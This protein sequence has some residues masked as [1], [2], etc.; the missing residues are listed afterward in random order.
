MDAFSLPHSAFA[1]LKWTVQSI[2]GEEAINELFGFTIHAT[3]KRR[4]IEAIMHEVGVEPL[5]LALVGQ[6]VSFRVGTHGPTRYGV[7]TAAEVQGHVVI[8]AEPGTRIRFEIAPRAYLLTKRRNSRIFQGLYVHQIVSIVL[9]ESGVSHRWELLRSYPKRVFCTQYDETDWD[10]VTRLLAEEGILCFFD[11]IESFPGGTTPVY[12]GPEESDWAKAAKV[13]STIGTVAGGVGGLTDNMVTD[14]IA[15]VGAGAS[16]LGDLMKPVPKDEEADD[17]LTPFTGQA[18]PGGDVDVL[19]FVD[20]S[21]GYVYVPPH[22]GEKEMK[23]VLH[24]EGGMEGSEDQITALWPSRHVRTRQSTVRDYDFRRPLLLLEAKSGTADD[25]KLLGG[26]KPLDTYA[27]H[28]EYEK[29]EVETFIAQTHLEQHRAD[30]YV[31]AGKS[32]CP[33]LG[34]GITFE[35]DAPG[36][37]LEDKRYAVVRVRHESHAPTSQSPS[38]MGPARA[39]TSGI[40]VNHEV[41]RFEALARGCARAIYEAMLSKEPIAEEAIG[42]VIRDELGAEPRKRVYKNRFECVPATVAYRPPRPPPLVRNVTESAVVVGPIG[43]GPISPGNADPNDPTA[44]NASKEIYTDRYGRVKIQ[45]HW[46]RDGKLDEHSSC[47]VRVAQTWAGA[48]FGFQFIP[49]VGMEVLVAFLRGDPD[50]PVIIGSLYNATHATPEPLPQRTTRSGIRTQSS[51]GGGGFN[52]LSF[53]DGKGVERVFVHAQKDFEEVVNDTHSLNVKNVQRVTVTK[54][55]EVSVGGDQITAVGGNH[56][57][58]VAKAQSITVQG[59]RSSAVANNETAL[60]NGNAFHVVSGVAARNVGTDEII[61]IAGDR[62][63]SVRGNLVTHVGGRYPDLKSS[64]ITYVQGSSFLTA[65]ERVVVK[66][67]TAAKDASHSSIRLE[68]G[69]S[70][71]QIEADKITLSAKQIEILGSEQIKA[72]GKDADLK[73]DKDGAKML[74]KQTAMGTPDGSGLALDGKDATLNAPG[75]TAVKGKEIKM[76][77]AKSDSD[78]P[79]NTS[80]NE[81]VPGKLKL[82]FTH[83]KPTDYGSN[84]KIANTP[85]R[86]VIEDQ[87]YEGNTDGDGLLEVPAPDTAK[88]A[89]VTLWANSKYPTQYTSGPLVWLVRIVKE[90]GDAGTPKG[91]R[92]RLR[93]LA[94]DPGTQLEPEKLDPVTAQA[95]VEFQLDEDLPATGELDDQT[96]K[97]LSEEYGTPQ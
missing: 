51:P 65:T 57:T 10:F 93:N 53:E 40:E 23:L 29:P 70:F 96:K 60:V 38:R 20:S 17:W 52:E 87:V 74:A 46:D 19:V 80:K 28:G 86:V 41:D 62:D 54:Q 55:Q 78:S 42:Q 44:N 14:T 71:L 5:E 30:A 82:V 24:D 7:V 72:K 32:Y 79:Q 25:P 56:A 45:F 97:K 13:A 39:G 16:V 3:A 4:E 81:K 77:S 83:L 85:Y 6:E 94:Y 91:A 88:A 58:L 26:E 64:A 61:S 18:G 43:L 1:P 66:A 69:D 84:N 11:H 47:W 59:N 34:A 95:I 33:R 50:R 67:E 49:R 68:C 89:Y 15:V 12:P 75:T 92:I 76:T 36:S 27:H 31:L 21:A 35:L 2:V 8:G 48:G 90:M 63:L 37:A 73:L 22:D 9:S